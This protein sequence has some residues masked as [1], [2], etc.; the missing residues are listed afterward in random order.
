MERYIMAVDQGT[1]SSRAILFDRHG[2]IAGMAQKELSNNYPHPGWAEQ[3]PDEWWDAVCRAIPEVLKKGRIDPAEIKGVGIDGQSWSAIAVD[4]EGNVL[5][6]TP[7][8]MDT[9]AV[10]ICDE[11]NEKIGREKIFELCGNPLQ[12]S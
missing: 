8:W 1:T 3:N 2:R 11:Y 4:S 10:D 12:P 9:R 7:I 5:T 6:N